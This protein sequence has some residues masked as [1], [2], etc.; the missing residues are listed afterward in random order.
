MSTTTRL[1]DKS[2]G[3]EN[4]TQR[5]VAFKEVDALDGGQYD[6]ETEDDTN[7]SNNSNDAQMLMMTVMHSTQDTG[8]LVGVFGVGRELES[9]PNLATVV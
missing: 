5:N 6:D 8:M 1:H 4:G 2:I 7:E 3:H 9:S